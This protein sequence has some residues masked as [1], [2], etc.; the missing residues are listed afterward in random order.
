ML[1]YFCGIATNDVINKQPSVDFEKSNERI[2]VLLEKIK[3][4]GYGCDFCISQHSTVNEIDLLIRSQENQLKYKKAFINMKTIFNTISIVNI[5]VTFVVF[6]D[7]KLIS[8]FGFLNAILVFISVYLIDPYIIYFECSVVFISIITVIKSYIAL[9]KII[10][11]INV[12]NE[13]ARR[14]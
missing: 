9:S 11:N 4:D 2:T 8:L 10:T 6:S 12:Q 5:L 1:I 3:K 13:L 14:R 7:P